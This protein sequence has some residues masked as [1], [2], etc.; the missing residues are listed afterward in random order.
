MLSCRYIV[1]LKKSEIK[2]KKVQ[3]VLDKHN[4]TIIIRNNWMREKQPQN[5]KE[6]TG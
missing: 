2:C 6:K 4:R 3:K 1:P 5:K